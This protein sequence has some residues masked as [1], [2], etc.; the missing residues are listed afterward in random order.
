VE[1]LQGARSLPETVELVKTK[2]RQFAKRQMTWYRRQLRVRWID[3]TADETAS[4]VAD[5]I[6]EEF[7]A[8]S[9]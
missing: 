5:R 7:T 6:Q 1:H 3:V 2:T 9:K 8:A 4:A